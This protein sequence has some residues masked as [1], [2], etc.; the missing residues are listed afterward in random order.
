MSISSAFLFFFSFFL[1]YIY[2]SGCVWF[3]VIRKE[4]KYVKENYLV[5]FDCLKKNLKENQIN[6]YVIKLFNLYIDMS[7]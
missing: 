4:K 6:L 1:F 2:H 3:W 7:K 5:M